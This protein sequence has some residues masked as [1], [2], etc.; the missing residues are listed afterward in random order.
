MKRKIS[1]GLIILSMFLLA[2]SR[3]YAQDVCYDSSVAC[4]GESICHQFLSRFLPDPC[5]GKRLYLSSTYGAS[6]L[7]ADISAVAILGI[8]AEEDSDDTF[9]VLHAI[10]LEKDHGAYRTRIEVEGGILGE[11]DWQFNANPGPALDFRLDD[12]WS[13]T[14]NVWVDVPLTEK[15]SV[16][17]GGGIGAAT[18]DFTLRSAFGSGGVDH[19]SFL[20]TA[21]T[22]VTYRWSECVHLDLG[23]RY[24]NMDRDSFDIYSDDVYFA[25]RFMH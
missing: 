8:N 19:F 6:R 3:L 23:Y 13:V 20:Y 9:S 21:G 16:F 10:G 4:C 17:G 18:G 14:T 12:I 15:F 5:S 2:G 24:R 25:M 11:A 22:G 7:N 1:I